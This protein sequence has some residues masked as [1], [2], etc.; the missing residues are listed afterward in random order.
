MKISNKQIAE[1]TLLTAVAILAAY[2][3]LV[4]QQHPELTETQTILKIIGL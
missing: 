3:T 1:I 4:M 2:C